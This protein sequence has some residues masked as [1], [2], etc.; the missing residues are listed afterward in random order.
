MRI[1]GDKVN[2]N[3]CKWKLEEQLAAFRMEFGRFLNCIAG[4]D[5]HGI[6]WRNLMTLGKSSP[7]VFTYMILMRIL[8]DKYLILLSKSVPEDR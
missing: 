5:T 7:F 1:G 6:K 2:S 8:T 4:W 3:K